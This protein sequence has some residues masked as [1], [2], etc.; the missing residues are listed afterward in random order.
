MYEMLEQGFH[1]KVL[2][3]FDRQ[4]IHFVFQFPFR[5]I[6]HCYYLAVFYVS[7]SLLSIIPAFNVFLSVLFFKKLRKFFLKT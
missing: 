3:N 4:V 5:D 2:V 1:G 6:P 7:L